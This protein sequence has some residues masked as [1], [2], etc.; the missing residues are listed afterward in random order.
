[1]PFAGLDMTNNSSAS[2]GLPYQ[3]IEDRLPNYPGVQD[4]T[5]HGRLPLKRSL[6]TESPE[7]FKRYRRQEPGI[8]KRLMAANWRE[9]ADRDEGG[10]YKHKIC[11]TAQRRYSYND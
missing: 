1:M 8:P 2:A 9:G 6:N 10:L 3:R 5:K 7:D 4:P 11:F